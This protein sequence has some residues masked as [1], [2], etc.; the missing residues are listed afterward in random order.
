M[1]P[2]MRLPAI[3]LALLLASLLASCGGG[4]DRSK[5]QLRLV[6]ASG[7]YAA[8]DL[9]VDEKRLQSAVAY[10]ATDRYVEVDPDQ[11]FTEV[12]RGGTTTPLVTTTP[13]L[14]EG[15]RYTL[16]AYGAEGALKAALLD[17]NASEPDS[18][19]VRL[20]VLNAAP[21]A[22]NVDVFLTAGDAQ[23]ADAEAL[24]PGAVAGTVSGFGE[25]NAATWRLRV[26]AAGDRDDL[27]LDISGIVLASRQIVTVVVTP[28]SGGVLVN[29]LVVTQRGAISALAGAQARVR[30]VA[31]V[32]DSG[33]VA[34]TVGGVSL[35]NGTG[36]PAAG[37]YRLVPSGAAAAAVTVNGVAVSVPAA[38]LSA[39][40]DHTLMVWGPAAAPAA[41][42]IADDNR[43]PTV[44]GRARLRLVHGVASLD[45]AI[46]LTLDF[47]PVADGVLGGTAS[48]PMQVDANAAA[49]LTVTAVGRG[50]P[51]WSAVDQSLAAGSVYTLFVVGGVNAPTGILRKDR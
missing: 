49:T 46:A 24:H 18:G 7:G 15:D 31:A 39:G 10:G 23:L 19:K 40:T 25:V 4:E 6:N 11:T 27:R 35:M 43:P 1:R 38:T 50:S 48:T 32:T 16:V 26:T 45:A 33:A 14:A 5:A 2:L 21:E 17:D 12:T 41:A 37:S 51:L 9:Y 34:A 29:A 36:A 30:A 47:S 42:W 8:L 28:G 3:A 13:A 22:G 20:R 44:A